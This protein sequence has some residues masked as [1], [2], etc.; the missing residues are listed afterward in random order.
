MREIAGR[1]GITERAV[2]QILTDLQSAGVL[3]R[4]RVGRRTVY[5]INPDVALRHP[6]ESHRTVGDI[7]RLIELA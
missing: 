3:T 4:R 7:L 1:V 6:V 2:A 5:D